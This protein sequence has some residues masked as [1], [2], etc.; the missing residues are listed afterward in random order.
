MLPIH[1]LPVCTE[2]ALGIGAV[3]AATTTGTLDLLF[4]AVEMLGV[5]AVVVGVTTDVVTALTVK[6]SKAPFVIGATGCSWCHPSRH[7]T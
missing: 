3:T 7:L 1:G 4:A 6:H 5:G 2:L